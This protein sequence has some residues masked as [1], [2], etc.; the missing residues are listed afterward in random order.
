[1]KK[2][3]QLL[4]RQLP[5]L[6]ALLAAA[7]YAF[8]LAPTISHTD[9]GEL[10]AVCYTS[11]VA[12]PTGYP[13]FTMLGGLFS[14]I[15]LGEPAFM[16]NVMALL[17]TAGGVYWWGRALDTFFAGMRVK[18]KEGDTATLRRVQFA[19]I[20]GIVVGSL[21]LAFNR[22]YWVQSAS[23]EV[24][25]LHCFLLGLNLFLLL[26]AWEQPK[27][28]G[29][30]AWLL[31]AG[32]L[33]LAFANHLTTVTLLPGIAWLYF[34]K[35]GLNAAAFKRLGLMLALFFALL[36]ALYAYL[37]IRAAADPAYNW[38]NPVGSAEIWHHVSGRQFSVWMFQGSK[39]FNANFQAFFTK[40]PGEFGYLALLLVVPGLIYNFQTRRDTAIFFTLNFLSTVFWA[41]NYTI[42]DPEPYFLLADICL[43]F[44][45]AC[46]LRWL[47]L[48]MRASQPVRYALSGVAGV[49]IVLCIPVNFA[50]CDQR[51]T[52]QYEDYTRAVL[53][54]LP[55]D[56][57]LVSRAYDW[58]ISPS[59]YVQGVQG[60]RQDVD[61]IDFA[62]LR[63]RHWYPDHLR[64]HMP[65]VTQALGPKLDEWEDVVQDFD[66]RGIVDGARLSRNFGAV[67]QGIL[68]SKRPIY[69]SPDMA[70]MALNPRE[71]SAIPQGYT[72]VPERYCLRMTSIAEAGSNY[73]PLSTPWEPIRLPKTLLETEDMGL[74]TQLGAILDTRE[75][76]ENALQHPQEAE[77]M[78]AL[79]ETLP[80][81]PRQQR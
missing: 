45:M 46:S 10:A 29:H 1:V 49:A 16:L 2:A 44:W 76:Y 37:P 12:H 75:R 61:V 28:A 65:D 26:R 79:R 50:H 20:G 42:K 69:F 52:W 36:I 31:F 77:A 30:K 4:D 40:L 59:Y 11:G 78:R 43:A 13:L 19:R 5:L 27:E 17:L 54:S 66:L 68:A 62:M 53:K 60:I 15:P 21:L 8:T 74:V 23:A 34:R 41:A 9:S 48:R 64:H 6:M 3:T 14:H 80:V 35:N 58:L 81:I 72:L 22:T 25:S 73:V 70:D 71:M 24:Y 51:G 55:Q 67:Y 18:V 33:A 56:A 63:D 32:A 7:V 38:G 57:I 39:E 47:W